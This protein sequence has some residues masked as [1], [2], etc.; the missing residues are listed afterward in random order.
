VRTLEL[1]EISATGEYEPERE[2]RTVE[3]KGLTDLIARQLDLRLGQWIV[4][5]SLGLRLRRQRR[6]EHE[7]VSNLAPRYIALYNGVWLVLNDLI[8]GQT[9]GIWLCENHEVAA[10][11]LSRWLRP[12][13]SEGLVDTLTWLDSW[14]LGVK[15]NTQLSRFFCD[16]FIGLTTVWDDFFI[17]RVIANDGQVLSKLLYC[18]GVSS[19]LMGLTMLLSIL[20][21][22]LQIFTFHWSVFYR[23]QQSIF[24]FFT[25]SIVSLFHLF[26]GKKRNPL[27]KNRTDDAVYDLDQLLLGTIFFTLFLFLFLTVAVYYWHFSLLRLAVVGLIT[28]LHTGLAFLNHLPLFALMLRM[29]EPD[30]LPGGVEMRLLDDQTKKAVINTFQCTYYDLYSTSLDLQDIF[31]GY[32]NHLQAIRNLPHLLWRLLLGRQILN[33]KFTCA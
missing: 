5:P 2:E 32:N 15:L 22:L 33:G 7:S 21:D 23:I 26:R 17:A 1:I 18:V 31:R 28:I 8:L 25:S 3:R 19:R 24:Q 27:R 6:K 16:L 14:P 30:R 9:V 29:K 10:K 20:V 11:L 4:W 12:V 13:L